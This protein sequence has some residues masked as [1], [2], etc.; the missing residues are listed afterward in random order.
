MTNEPYVQYGLFGD[1][2]REPIVNVASVPQRS[3]FRYPGGKTWLVPT[4]RRWL[5]TLPCRPTEFIEPFAGGGIVGL[6][7][8][9]E[10]RAERVTL[11]ELDEDVASVWRT[12]L[13]GEAEWLAHQILSFPFKE[14]RVDEV[15][16]Q[17]PK[18]HGERAFQ[19]ILRN[20]VNRGGILAPGSGRIK[21]GENGRGMASRWYPETLARR[22]RAIGAIR[23]RLRLVQ[24]DGLAVMQAYADHP[25]VAFFIDPPYTA[26][27][28]KAGARL[29]RHSEL[30]HEALFT[31]TA[32]VQ[33]DFLM[34]YDLTQAVQEMAVRHGL[35]YVP[36]AMKN[37]HHAEMTEL[38][39][40]R[41]LAWV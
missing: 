5:A 20:R 17:T 39:I 6:T 22:I 29:Y 36:V 9:F 1:E 24:G 28:K 23:N 4:V 38:L 18:D 30:D 21:V 37:T 25:A 7:V 33:G 3:P 2:K 14:Q 31:L 40:G 26:S 41:S 32:S 10:Q 35:Q 27:G 11:V 19:T 15:L 16:R 13:E 8:A 34:T 12:I